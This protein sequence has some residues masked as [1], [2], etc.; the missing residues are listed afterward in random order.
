ML[1]TDTQ[2]CTQTRNTHS[3]NM[4]HSRA[5]SYRAECTTSTSQRPTVLR[6]RQTTTMYEEISTQPRSHSHTNVN[7]PNFT[8]INI[9]ITREFHNKMCFAHKRIT[10]CVCVQRTV[11]RDL[12]YD[13]RQLEPEAH[14]KSTND[15]SAKRNNHLNP[16]EALIRLATVFIDTGV[17]G[18]APLALDR[19]LFD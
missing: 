5:K 7:P 1:N 6:T 11:A 8:P 17:A 12:I 16:S 9:S 19:E 13:P 14:I 3:L 18:L 2:A 10:R 15:R 4:R